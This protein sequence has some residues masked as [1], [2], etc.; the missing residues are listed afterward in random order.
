MDLGI[1]G[2]RVAIEVI[3]TLVHIKS[4]MAELVLKPAGIPVDCYRSLLHRRDDSTGR[5]LSKR[6]SLHSS[7]RQSSN[8]ALV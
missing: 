1:E 7:S 8:A 5:P 6:R 4:T 3:A 2:Q